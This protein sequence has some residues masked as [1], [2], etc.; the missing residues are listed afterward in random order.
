MIV[1]NHDPVHDLELNRG[2]R[3]AQLVFQQV[4]YAR[5]V[6]VDALPDSDRGAG[7]HGSTGGSSALERAGN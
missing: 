6:E 1:I 4:S 2:D 7:G 3:I 5:F